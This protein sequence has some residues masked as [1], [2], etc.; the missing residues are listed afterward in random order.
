MKSP[1]TEQVRALLKRHGLTGAEA[2]RLMY[3]S[4]SRQVRKYTGGQ[5]PRQMDLA[6]W[7]TLHAKLILPQSA[8]DRIEAAMRGDDHE[9][10]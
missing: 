5:S 8:I 4:G 7:F 1:T 10:H 6:R 2:A 3:L 9:N